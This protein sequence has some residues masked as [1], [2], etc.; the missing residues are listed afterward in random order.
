MVYRLPQRQT[1]EYI[2]RTILT[3]LGISAML[4]SPLSFAEETD[5]PNINAQSMQ[6]S[7]TLYGVKSEGLVQCAALIIASEFIA[8]QVKEETEI[9]NEEL[10]MQAAINTLK[11]EADERN[12][13]FS[14]DDTSQRA[15]Q[16]MITHMKEYVDEIIANI[17]QENQG[18]RL[19][20]DMLVCS[21]LASIVSARFED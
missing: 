4:L 10:L 13:T 9:G 3:T 14:F 7:N 15:K 16:E 2:M 5:L 21:E 12:E 6:S 11:H 20:N 17:E 8:R 19:E 1:K 18:E